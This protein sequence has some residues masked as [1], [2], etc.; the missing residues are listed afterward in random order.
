MSFIGDCY[1]PHC[2][3]CGTKTED[4]G[5]EA[6]IRSSEARQWNCCHVRC[7]NCR[8]EADWWDDNGHLQLSQTDSTPQERNDRAMEA[9]SSASKPCSLAKCRRQKTGVSGESVMRKCTKPDSS[10][11]RIT[12]GGKPRSGSASKRCSKRPH[13]P[14]VTS[15]GPLGRNVSPR[16]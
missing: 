14:A 4:C 3:Q 10:R 2:L 12:K 6:S 16:G 9:R 11:S 15:R 7:P 1:A 13:E 8:F 5:R